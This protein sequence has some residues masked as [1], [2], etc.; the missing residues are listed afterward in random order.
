MPNLPTNMA[1]DVGNSRIKYGLFAGDQLLQTG[2]LDTYDTHELQHLAYNHQ[3]KNIIISSTGA[4]TSQIRQ[5]LEADFRTI[6]L[7][8]ITPL[9]VKVAYET[10]E[11]LGKDR[12]AAIVGASHLFPEKNCLVL[13]AGTCITYD[14]LA[15]GVYLGGNIAPGLHMRLKAMHEFTARLPD[16]TPGEMGHSVGKSTETAIRNGAQ[17]GIRFEL[18]G[19]LKTWET[20]YGS[21]VVL[22]TGG[23]AAFFDKMLKREIFV[24]SHLV[25]IGLNK[26]LNYNA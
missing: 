8:H 3:V 16:I 17:W 1:V 21:L 25:L 9:P 26:I 2:V 13:D 15:D 19:Y 11:T 10:P 6:S 24:N 14:L 7:D 5:R 4:D 18:E 20:I 12:L 22:V 23:D